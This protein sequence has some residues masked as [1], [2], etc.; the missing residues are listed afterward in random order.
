V[1]DADQN[2]PF[3]TKTPKSTT[4]C[5]EPLETECDVQRQR[6]DRNGVASDPGRE[7]N[8]RRNS[9]IEWH[10]HARVPEHFRDAL[11]EYARGEMRRR[12]HMTA[13]NDHRSRPL[14]AT[15]GDDDDSSCIV[16]NR[17]RPPEAGDGL[18]T[19]YSEH[20]RHRF[21]EKRIHKISLDRR[22]TI[23]GATRRPSRASR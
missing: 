22:C 20:E 8:G 1:G 21:R 12:H 13:Q 9:L 3:I 7:W 11:F 2:Q 5:S 23:S 15:N 17:E 18:V 19:R 4:H 10:L 16:G 6:N 14:E